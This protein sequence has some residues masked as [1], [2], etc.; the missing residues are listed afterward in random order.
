M[1]LTRLLLPVADGAPEDVHRRLDHQRPA[2]RR[3]LA[4]VALVAL[5][6]LALTACG[7]D[8]EPAAG[9]PPASTAAP[10]TTGAP[11]TTEAAPATT[12]APETTGVSAA[13]GTAETL[14]QQF[15]VAAPGRY[16]TDVLGVTV[17][18]DTP[19]DLLI[20]LHA[21]GRI[22]MVDGFDPATGEYPP[23]TGIALGFR[24]WAGWSTAEEAT[25]DVPS[26]SIEPYDV[27]AWFAAND[28]IVLSDETTTVAD[29]PARVF[30][31]T[32][33]PDTDMGADAAGHGACFEGWEPCFYIGS[34]APE[35]DTLSDWVSAKRVTRFYLVTI[36]G[37]EPVLI[38]VGA[39]EG[40]PWFDEVESTV[41]ATLE[42]GPDALPLG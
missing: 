28:V 18:Y 19:R 34:A 42:L 4:L 7:D 16:T 32:V 26:A 40:D 22:G 36:D 38:S 27:D 17:S 11:A 9:D 6:A 35:T 39:P 24:R 15:E 20:T 12:E 8:D 1:K 3:A 37:S 33:D 30:E 14:P 31:V 29:H 5:G 23:E 25:A 10:D 13:I 41:I 21:P 2:T